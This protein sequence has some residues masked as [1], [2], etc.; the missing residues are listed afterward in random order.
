MAVTYNEPMSRRLLVPALAAVLAA[1]A[2][3]AGCG[4]GSAD[5]KANEAYA[6]GVCTAVGNWLTA[7]ERADTA[8]P[9][10]GITK[11][12][13]EAKLHR[14]ET[15]TNH[16]VS[17]LGA[18]PAPNTSEGRAAKREIDGQLIPSARGES[19]AAKTVVSTIDAGG[20][21]TQLAAALATLPDYRTLK[22]KTQQ[23]LT[24]GA[25]GSLASAFKSE[26][27]CKRLG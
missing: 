12:S 2:L 20:G 22:A 24:L 8:P 18:V 4:G 5:S 1:A 17:Q 27:A 16:F 7:V 14:F 9:V 3:L 19:T 10:G 21:M 26:P 25:S 13:I 6:S 11:A 23:T 15:A